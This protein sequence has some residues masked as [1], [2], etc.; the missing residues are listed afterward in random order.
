MKTS[1]TIAKVG[2]SHQWTARRGNHKVNHRY[3]RRRQCLEQL[4]QFLRS[5]RNG[6][7][8]VD[9]L[10]PAEREFFFGTLTK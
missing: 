10:T 9:G 2:K 4:A 8:A 6:D 7:F 5:I 3:D 1:F